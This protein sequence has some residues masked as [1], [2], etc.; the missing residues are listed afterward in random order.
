[1]TLGG[2]GR[3]QESRETGGVT[4]KDVLTGGRGAAWEAWPCPLTNGLGL[5][6][7]FTPKC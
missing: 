3:D 4:E 2:R 6:L 1:M 7:D 5:P